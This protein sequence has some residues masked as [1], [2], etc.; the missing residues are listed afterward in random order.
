F[1]VV[2]IAFWWKEAKAEARAP[3]LTEANSQ[4]GF[5]FW[6]QGESPCWYSPLLQCRSD[7]LSLSA[8]LTIG[9]RHVIG[10]RG[11]T[12]HIDHLPDGNGRGFGSIVADETDL[13]EARLAR[14]RRKVRR[15]ED[16]AALLVTLRI[17]LCGCLR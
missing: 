7:H 17:P 15:I 8:P 9:E 14:H 16:K 3:R 5:R 13:H 12:W 11:R 4:N 1:R 10:P 6:K 2:A